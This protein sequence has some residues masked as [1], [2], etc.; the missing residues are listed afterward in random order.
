[1]NFVGL[2]CCFLGAVQVDICFSA[3]SFNYVFQCDFF[4]I[5]FYSFQTL[6]PQRDELEELFGTDWGRLCGESVT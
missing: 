6:H 5:T 2:D 1:M 4:K 3:I